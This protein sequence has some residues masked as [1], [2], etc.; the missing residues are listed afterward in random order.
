MGL[1]DNLWMSGTI[2]LFNLEKYQLILATSAQSLF[3]RY[4][5]IFRAISRD[6]CKIFTE[7]EINCSSIFLSVFNITNF[8]HNLYLCLL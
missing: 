1:V 4:Q 7:P 2:I 8:R 3:G 5:A 6:N